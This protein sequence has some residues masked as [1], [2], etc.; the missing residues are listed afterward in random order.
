M[1]IS[2]LFNYAMKAWEKWLRKRA[3]YGLQRRLNR[4]VKK[5]ITLLL[6]E[7]FYFGCCLSHKIVRKQMAN[8]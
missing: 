4:C 5:A 2:I 7:T 8:F 3:V 1:H 6:C